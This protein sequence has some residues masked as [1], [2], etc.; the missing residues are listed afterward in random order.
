MDL[1]LASILKAS[2][3]VA[4]IL[5]AFSLINLTVPMSA[6]LVNQ[7]I[8]QTQI[9]QTIGLMNATSKTISTRF[10][11]T[12]TGMNKSLTGTNG[13]FSANPTIFQ[14]FA[15]ILE[16]FGTMM[17]DIV[18][19]PYLDIISLNYLAA[20]MQIAM[21]S[22]AI[23]FI[24]MGIDLLYGYMLITILLLGVSMIQKYNAKT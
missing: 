23:G 14:S 24:K 15:F 4:F 10:L 17:T 2:L 21:P 18:M 1:N 8:N 12:V 19:L 6:P 16:G 5:P 7:G 13:S 22:Y 20:G 11:T 3:I 9:N